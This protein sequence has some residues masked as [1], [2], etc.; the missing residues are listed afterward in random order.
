MKQYRPL[1]SV[2]LGLVLLLQGFAV[3]AA[4]RAKIADAGDAQHAAVA[5]SDMPCHAKSAGKATDGQKQKP[6]CCD[7]S[8]ADMTTCSLGHMAVAPVLVVANLPAPDAP[9]AAPVSEPV[10]STPQSLLRPPISLHG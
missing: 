8:C 6:S 7:G 2:L 3:A 10:E 5:V 1:L 9:S 4:P